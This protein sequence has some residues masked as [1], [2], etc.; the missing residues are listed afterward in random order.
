M[1]MNWSSRIPRKVIG[2][3]APLGATE[4]SGYEFYR[5]APKNVMCIYMPVGVEKFSAADVHRAFKPIDAMV[6]AMLNRDVDIIVQSGTPLPI[7]IGIKAHDKLMNRIAKRSGL[8]VT[9]TI[10]SVINSSRHMGIK[11]L[12]LVNKWSDKMNATLGKFLARRGIKVA[13]LCTESMNPG[14][15]LKLNSQN[16]MDMA[17]EM[18][19]TALERNPKADGIYIG[20]GAWLALPVCERLE[21]KLGIPVISNQDA[22]LWDCLHKIDH[23]YP[24]KGS[25]MLLGGD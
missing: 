21:K 20:G 14:Q 2:T 12:A 24:K 6:D 8:P 7:L 3:L 9:S 1:G 18:A 13:S 25:T 23:W 5:I 10:E 22:V 17:W 15:F 19:M 11:N 4:Y 16:G